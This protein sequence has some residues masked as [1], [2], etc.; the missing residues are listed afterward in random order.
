MAECLIL[1]KHNYKF[2]AFYTRSVCE[3]K[4]INFSDFELDRRQSCSC[5]EVCYE[6]SD[7]LSGQLEKVIQKATSQLENYKSS[8]VINSIIFLNINNDDW[9]PEAQ[10]SVYQKISL[11][12]Q[13]FTKDNLEIIINL[14]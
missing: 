1:K 13:N 14:T 6:L 2:D 10:S 11:F 9:Q 12:V 5:K 4:T 8:N 3:V 7:N